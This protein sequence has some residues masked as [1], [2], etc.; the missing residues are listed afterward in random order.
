MPTFAMVPV[1][2]LQPLA[3]VVSARFVD[4]PV[5]CSTSSPVVQSIVVVSGGK[6]LSFEL[7]LRTY[8]HDF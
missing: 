7:E 6:P 4:Q 1:A 5:C 2:L 3:V 8:I